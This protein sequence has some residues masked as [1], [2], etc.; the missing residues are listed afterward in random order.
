[1]TSGWA[2]IV[3]IALG[4]LLKQSKQWNTKVYATMIG[5]IFLL[6]CYLWISNGT[7]IVKYLTTMA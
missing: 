7:L 4:Y 5:I 2:F 6:S 1:M 3:P